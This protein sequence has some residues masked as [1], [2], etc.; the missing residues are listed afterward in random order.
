M[1]YL[2]KLILTL[3][4]SVGSAISATAATE[5]VTSNKPAKNSGNYQD[6]DRV[7]VVVNS[8][9]ITQQE[10]NEQV[11]LITKQLQEAKRPVP[12]TQELQKQVLDKM[13]IESIQ[14]QEAKTRGI[15][16]VDA[17]LDAVIANIATQKKMTVAQ[18]QASIE[19]SGLNYNKYKE[20]LRKEVMIA[21]FR[22]RE[23][24]TRIKISDSDVDNF[25]AERNRASG[26]PSGAAAAVNNSDSIYLAQ[27][28]V[29]VSESPNQE[30]LN[31]AKAKA[32]NILMQASGESDFIAFA[33]R[34]GKSDPT[35]RVV[36]LGFRTA[37]RLPELFV[38]ASASLKPGQL[39]PTVLQS[40][41]GFHVLKL[42]D[43]KTTGKASAPTTAQTTSGSIIVVQ[44]EVRHLLVLAR[45]GQIDQDVARRLV[46]FR[47]QVRAK[48]VEFTSLAKKYSEDKQSA[49]NGGY[50]GWISPGQLPPEFDVAIAAMQPGSVSDPIRTDFGWHLIQ[51]I[52]RK[53]SE[54]SPNQQKDFAK[55]SLRQSK[56][57]QAYS[58]WI[59]ELRG[60]ATVEYRPPYDGKQ[61]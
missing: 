9:V 45:A 34:L 24:D 42:I 30:E 58:D 54:L 60:T 27:I 33:N 29:P 21:R 8:S 49:A 22:E 16:V 4:L 57:E 28:L 23:V 11:R 61:Q 6:I 14:Y 41:A 51:L 32:G 26:V 39:S 25:I 10:L 52:N 13:V 1:N 43:R 7:I 15:R 19:K 18:Y 47:D 46:T 55:A 3:A 59:Q 35:I 38:Q 56:L 36:D 20:D 53:Q 37:D 40:P 50:L 44:N 31:V 17:E 12:P 5:P 48:T 2:P